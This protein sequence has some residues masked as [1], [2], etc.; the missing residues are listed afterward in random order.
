MPAMRDKLGDPAEFGRGTLAL[1]I[2]PADMPVEPEGGEFGSGLIRGFA[3]ITRGE[4]L[5]HDL[6]IDKTFLQQVADSLNAEQG[7]AKSRFTHPGLSADGLGKYLGRAHKA[8]VDGDTIRADLHLAQSAH[9]SPDGDLAAYVMQLATEDA[10]AFGASI[11]FAHDFDAED[12]FENDHLQEVEE[13]DWRGQPVKRMRFRS[14]DPENTKHLRHA[15][16]AALRAVDIVDS[17]AANP[18]GLF[19]RGDAI[20]DEAE[21]LLSFALG[22]SEEAP[23]A[24]SF[25]VHPQRVQSFVAKF[26]ERHR[27]SVVNKDE[28]MSTATTPQTGNPP[29]GETKP[30]EGREQF[31]AELNRYVTRFGAEN[32]TAWFTS[33]KSWEQALE[34]HAVVLEA[35]LT[36]SRKEVEEL[37]AKLASLDRGETDPVSTS[38]DGNAGSKKKSSLASLISMP[39]AS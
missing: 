3:V 26:L 12:E 34:A 20:A 33:G 17:P 37:T 2:A 19:R 18:N 16:L 21:S 6:W 31:A 36:A 24:S 25:D 23:V 28:A 7:G 13:T 4:A 10:A 15:R 5:G 14:P 22:L 27:L 9:R 35:Q 32:G 39:S 11:V 29:A 30:A 1:G 8:T 38:G